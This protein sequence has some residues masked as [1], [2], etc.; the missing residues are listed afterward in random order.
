MPAMSLKLKLNRRIDSISMIVN[1][2]RM[3]LSRNVISAIAFGAALIASTS[4]SSASAAE[5][6]ISGSTTVQDRILEPLA[7]DIKAAT[8][9]A[10]KVEGIGSGNGLKRLI[11]GEAQV[12]IISAE[13]KDLLRNAQISDD[14]TYRQHVLL[15]DIIVP[16]VNAKNPVKELSWEQL[17]GLFSGKIKNWSEVGGPEIP[18]RIVTSHPESATRE[19]VWELV[20]GK[21]DFHRS[22]RIVYATKKELVLVAESDGALGAVS[23]G[24]V[25]QYLAEIAKAG[26]PA[27]IKV[28]STK[29][30][31]RPL[32]MVTKGEPEPQV[33]KLLAFLQSEK[34]R[35]NFR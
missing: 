17:K 29:R 35:K 27:E 15:E 24:F 14:G 18:V 16:I 28:V 26:D 1:F 25:D 4:F 33:A 10:I 7:P 11:N 6:L 13:L 3:E 12:A 2:R 19:V 31:S 5:F 9:I 8:G 22:A 30:I 34:A 21:T 23:Q 20:M 32:A